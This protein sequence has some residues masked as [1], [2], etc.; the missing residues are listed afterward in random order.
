MVES[1][2]DRAL[3]EALRKNGT[4]WCCFSVIARSLREVCDG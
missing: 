3:R 2:G 4:G 1:A